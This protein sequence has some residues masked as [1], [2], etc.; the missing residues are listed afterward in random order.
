[1]LPEIP[2]LDV[3]ADWPFETLDREFGRVQA[4][5]DEGSGRFPGVVVRVADG[6][7]RR[8]LK[9]W[10]EP[11]LEEIDR[12]AARLG[13]PGAYF[14]NVSYEWGC[15]SSAGPSP[16][17]RSARL[18]RVLDWPDRGLGRHV[19]AARVDGEAGPWL[20]LTWPGYTGVLQAVAPGRFAA[21]LN[22]APM[23]KPV[24]FY[25]LDWFVNRVKV[26]DRPHL[27]AAHLLRRVFERARDF[28]E[29]KAMLSETPIALPTIYILAGLAPEDA[30]VIERMPEE[31]HVIEGCAA[32]DNAW[33]APHWPGRVRGKDNG[34]RRDR[35]RSAAPSAAGDFAWLQPPILNPWTRLVFMADAARGSALAQGFEADGPATAVLTWSAAAEPRD[36]A[37]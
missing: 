10:H 23:E 32:A 33:Q 22:Q 11:H 28:A 3:G 25:P 2:L 18:M 20:T 21:A 8:W 30:C 9:R 37:A 24:G 26:W 34:V 19:I 13:R 4:L 29:A 1:M 12:I 5:L 31:A 15:T 35:M 27:M 6:I 36:P 14:L 7:S 16:D 17:G